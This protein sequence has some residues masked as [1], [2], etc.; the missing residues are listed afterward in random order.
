MGYRDDMPLWFNGWKRGDP[1]AEMLVQRGI[2]SEN[3]LI[4][5]PDEKEELSRDDNSDNGGSL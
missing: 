2:I 1:I 5:D 4:D 3:D